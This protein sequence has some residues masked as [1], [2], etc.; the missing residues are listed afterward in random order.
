VKVAETSL[1]TIAVPHDV[2]CKIVQTAAES[3]GGV[4][5]R[6][7]GVEVSGGTAS[8]RLSVDYGLVVPEVA[9]E[10]QQRVGEALRTMC[11]IAPAAV[12][13]AVQELER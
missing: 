5:V 1:G 7:R 8:L 4:R 11:G 10:V 6:R 13:V 9:R 2:V 12:D 3:V